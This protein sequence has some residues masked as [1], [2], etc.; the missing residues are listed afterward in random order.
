M[1]VKVCLLPEG[2]DPDSFARKNGAAA[3]TEY[4]EQ[5]AEDFIRFKTAVLLKDAG[6]DPVK[7]ASIVSD[8][9]QSIAII[10]D[11]IMRSVY[12]KQ[13]SEMLEIAENVLYESV[14]KLRKKRLHDQKPSEGKIGASVTKSTIIPPILQGDTEPVVYQFER[15]IIWLLFE[16]GD[17]EL[18][19]EE[20]DNDSDGEESLIAV[21][22]FVLN[23]LNR[24]GLSFSHPVLGR[25]LDE[26]L[27]FHLQNISF[28][29]KYFFNHEDQHVVKEMVDISSKSYHPS[30]IWSKHSKYDRMDDTDLT[31]IIERLLIEYKIERVQLL[32]KEIKG[33]LEKDELSQDER[34]ALLAEFA[35][36][37]QVRVALGRNLPNRIFY[38]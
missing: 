16:H 33:K 26:M 5:H 36:Y 28:S 23:D 8:I 12:L 29:E 31:S 19:F 30:K 27:N 21:S 20:P 11:S 24:E 4:I 2:E 34:M 1:N 37:N 14:N 17:K 22:E 9:V 10:P 18:Y 25:I 3:T 7:K 38:W 13:T 32:I 6:S 35:R 15:E